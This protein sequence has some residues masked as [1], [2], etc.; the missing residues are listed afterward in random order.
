MTTIIEAKK[1]EAGL[2]SRLA[3]ETDPLVRELL[4][5]KIRSVSQLIIRESVRISHQREKNSREFTN[6]Q[7]A[8]IKCGLRGATGHSLPD[9]QRHWFWDGVSEK[10]ARRLEKV[11][12]GIKEIL[13][14]DADKA[15]V[16][17]F[18]LLGGVKKALKEIGLPAILGLPESVRREKS[19]L[20]M[21]L[22]QSKINGEQDVKHL[23]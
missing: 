7:E 3:I 5:D 2:K 12:Q 6:T 14:H 13:F 17:K 23:V 10:D 16:R 21:S 22:V 19:G 9:K 8:K 4:I 20:I 15:L 18:L 11:R 1:I